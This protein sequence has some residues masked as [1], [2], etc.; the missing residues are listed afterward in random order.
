M[1]KT[2]LA[3]VDGFTPVI[4]GMI[5]EVGLITAVI[6]GKAWRYCQMADGVCKASQERIAAELGIT[7][8]TVNAHFSRL[9]EFG[10]LKDTTPDLA[11]LPHEYSDTGKANLSISFTGTTATCKKDLQPPVKNIDTKKVVKKVL[12]KEKDIPP[13]D[14][15]GLPVSEYRKI[16]EIRL[17]MDATKWIPG[18]FVLET[19]YEFVH[20]GLT[21]EQISTA[22]KAWCARGYR[23]ANV[24]GYLE[25]ARD[26]IPPAKGN[27]GSKNNSA[28]SPRPAI[29]EPSS[30]DLDAARIVLAQRA[31][32]NP[33][34]T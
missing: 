2:I 16:P 33:A 19:V 9:C 24:Q 17:F 23:A 34:P 5:P 7:R 30:A 13:P 29:Q 14:L 25:W 18:S 15:Q 8:A 6:F 31:Q 26:G 10:Y 11:G 22:F 4:D 21:E 32:A 27:Y 20:A 3:Q 28:S 12:K 1:S